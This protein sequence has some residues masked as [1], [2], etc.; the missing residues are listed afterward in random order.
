MDIP[1]GAKVKIQSNLVT[2]A[3]ASL[4]GNA[5]DAIQSKGKIEIRAQ[6][7]G[8]FVLC[9]VVNS[10]G[11]IPEAIVNQLFW[12]GISGKHGH[13]GWG[14]YLVLRSLQEY[15]GYLSLI[16]KCNRNMLYAPS[17][18]GNKCIACLVSSRAVTEKRK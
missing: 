2:L 7:E 1:D 16:F 11:P 12:P 13:S 6:V 4:I 3:L 9:H 8:D 5:I 10:G 14:L 17:A 15:E 18:G